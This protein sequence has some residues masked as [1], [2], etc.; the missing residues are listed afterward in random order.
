MSRALQSVGQ[1]QPTEGSSECQQEHKLHGT[2]GCF[3]CYTEDDGRRFVELANKCGWPYLEEREDPVQVEGMGLLFL[4]RETLQNMAE[5][6][7]KSYR[8]QTGTQ[9][10]FLVG[11]LNLNGLF[12]TADGFYR[13]YVSPDLEFLG[14]SWEKALQK[15]QSV[16]Y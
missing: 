12:L 5:E 15:L 4:D 13:E 11:V 9:D 16:E 3:P 6:N 14:G 7:M 2:Y 1:F 8:E 10:V